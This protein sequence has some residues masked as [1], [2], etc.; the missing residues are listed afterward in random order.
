[1]SFGIGTQQCDRFVRSKTGFCSAHSALVQDHCVHG[2]GTL[3]PAIHQFAADV[4]PTEMKVA[5][6]QVDPYEKTIHGDQALLGVVAQ[7]Q[8]AFIL[9]SWPSL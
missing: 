3:G 6:V 2:G 4:K 9:L 8:M 1:V 7:F 5:A